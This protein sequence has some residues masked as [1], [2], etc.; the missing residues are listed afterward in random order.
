MAKTRRQLDEPS[1]SASSGKDNRGRFVPGNKLA[2]G[3]PLAR[4]VQALRVSLIDSVS[5]DDLAAVIRRL[6]REAK[7][8]DVSAAKIL[9][10]RL[11]GPIQAVDLLERIERLETLVLSQRK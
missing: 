2:Q 8:G 5:P 10:D 4:K 11:L 3:N 9:F 7:S 1:P 6:L